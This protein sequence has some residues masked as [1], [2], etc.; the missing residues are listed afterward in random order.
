[1]GVDFDFYL[2]NKMPQRDYDPTWR[3]YYPSGL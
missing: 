2:A 1:L 3:I